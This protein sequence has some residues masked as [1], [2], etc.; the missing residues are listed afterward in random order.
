MSNLQQVQQQNILLTQKVN[1]LS[2][3]LN[4]A[5]RK[6]QDKEA[7]IKSTESENRKNLAEISRLHSENYRLV[8]QANRATC[9]RCSMR[10]N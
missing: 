7:I 9:Q 4:D 1:E 2:Q 3:R 5:N 6:I 10:S 8:Q